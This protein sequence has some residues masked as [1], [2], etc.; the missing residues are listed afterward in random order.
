[1]T[2]GLSTYAYFWRSSDRVAQPMS[3]H[4]ILEDTRSSGCSLL[5]ICDFAPLDDLSPAELDELGRAASDLGVRLEL[6]TRG[7]ADDHLRRYL[8]IATR[9]GATLVRSMLNTTAHQPTEA[10]AVESLRRAVPRYAERGVT[11]ALETYEQVPVAQLMRVIDAVGS[12]AL[13]ICLD[14]GN[15][16][17]ALEM[18]HHVVAATASHVKNWHVKDFA[19]TRHPGWVGFNLSGCLLG[20]GLLDYDGIRTAI[21]PDANG[22]NQIVEHWLPWQHDAEATCATEAQWTQHSI[23][24]LRSKS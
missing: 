9:L 6:G 16:V 1:M 17:A 4:H 23:N 12:E 18:P 13:G 2:I 15:C 20:E 22:I 11:L 24:Y 8:D 19:F 14:P 21:D 5:Q 10:E 7:I 3:L